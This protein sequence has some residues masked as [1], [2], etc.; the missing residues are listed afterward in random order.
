[1]GQNSHTAVMINRPNPKQVKDDKKLIKLNLKDHIK[2][3]VKKNNYNSSQENYLSQKF[4]KH[5]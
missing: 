5:S 4:E 2:T 3:L 1:M